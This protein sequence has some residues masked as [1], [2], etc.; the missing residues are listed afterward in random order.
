VVEGADTADVEAGGGL[1]ATAGAGAGAGA[2]AG[3]G[4][5]DGDD[6]GAG[7]DPTTMGM[8]LPGSCALTVEPEIVSE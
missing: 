2:E 5:G 6:D 7:D 3:A 1:E 8:P 4:A